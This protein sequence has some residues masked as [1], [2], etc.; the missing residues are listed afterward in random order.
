MC[1]L[2]LFGSAYA[3]SFRYVICNVVDVY[4][5]SNSYIWIISIYNIETIQCVCLCFSFLLKH[6]PFCMLYVMYY[7][8]ECI[9]RFCLHL[10]VYIHN[11]NFYHVYF[12]LLYTDERCYV[13]CPSL[14]FSF[15]IIMLFVGFHPFVIVLLY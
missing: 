8:L 1:L 11:Y 15:C 6:S 5:Y 4:F 3:F 12:H 9:L 13:M 2:I 10:I 14:I 7:A